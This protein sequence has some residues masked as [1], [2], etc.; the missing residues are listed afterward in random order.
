MDRSEFVPE[1]EMY[2]V[3]WDFKIKMDHPILVRSPDLILVNKKNLSTNGHHYSSRGQNVCV[4]KESE[5]LDKISGPC[6]KVKT[7]ET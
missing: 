1:N 6:Q 5:K 3:L 4:C 7:S 2:K